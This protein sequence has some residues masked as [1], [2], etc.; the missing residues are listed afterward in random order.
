MDLTGM[1][2]GRAHFFSTNDQPREPV[3]TTMQAVLSASVR[4]TFAELALIA[5]CPRDDIDVAARLND[6][7][8]Y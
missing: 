4:C 2:T 6:S 5:L 7:R 8:L 1:M 3:H